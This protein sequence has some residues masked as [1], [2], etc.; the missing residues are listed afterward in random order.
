MRGVAEE[1]A[2]R[3]ASVSCEVDSQIV[4]GVLI[5]TNGNCQS[6]FPIID[7]VPILLPQLRA[8]VA[9]NI[10]PIIARND[11]SPITESI[12]GDCCSQGSV[13]ESMRQLL[14]CYVWGHYSDLDPGETH[15]SPNPGSVLEVLDRGLEMVS[16][17]GTPPT[18]QHATAPETHSVVGPSID[19]G[20]GPGRTAMA[21]AQRTDQ[22]VL[23]V[24]INFSML[25][26]AST[27]LRTGRVTYPRR[28]IGLVYDRRE[29]E[30]AI[31]HLERVDF[32]ACDALALPFSAGL[33]SQ[34]VAMNVLD[35]VGSPITLLR[36]IARVLRPNGDAVLGCPYDWNT[37]V[38]PIESWL[39]GHSQRNANSGDSVPVLRSLLSEIGSPSGQV[40]PSL[41]FVNERDGIPWN[42]R[43]HDRCSMQYRVHLVHAKQYQSDSPTSFTDIVH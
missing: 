16:Q 11:L 3:L 7:G 29:F 2:L 35:S 24:D 13:L 41:R 17:C 21:I 30:L 22:L 10:F 19:V 34:A 8:Y 4:E 38:T 28:R 6:E 5:C 39:G 40:E 25:R 12:L 26:V 14:S 42:I 23:G 27:V 31:P 32:W 36:S 18:I 20:C 15:E 9:E 1:F 43:L 33:F 37:L